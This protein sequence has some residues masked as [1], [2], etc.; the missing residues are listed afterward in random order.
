MTPRTLTCSHVENTRNSSNDRAAKQAVHK[1]RGW[2]IFV[3]GSTCAFELWACSPKRDER[4][5]GCG[6]G[7][8]G[9]IR[10][11]GT[12]DGGNGGEAGGC[13]IHSFM[14]PGFT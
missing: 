9:G 1:V 6:W 14:I 12:G 7:R 5:T 3:V 8:W 11:E 13:E 2:K 10:G 4:G